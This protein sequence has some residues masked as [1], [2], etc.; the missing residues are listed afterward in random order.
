MGQKEIKM[1]EK[2]LKH[3]L[4]QSFDFATWKELLPLFFKKYMI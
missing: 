3:K 2:D 4:Q 1:K